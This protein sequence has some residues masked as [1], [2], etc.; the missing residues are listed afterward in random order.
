MPHMTH[1]GPG[2]AGGGEELGGIR[3]VTKYMQRTAIQGSLTFSQQLVGSG[4]RGAT[5]VTGG[6]HPFTRHFNDLKT[7][8]TYIPYLDKSHWRISKSSLISLA[9]NSMRI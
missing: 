6:S 3:A 4:C 9:I 5:E 2:R 8:D 1:G 7:G